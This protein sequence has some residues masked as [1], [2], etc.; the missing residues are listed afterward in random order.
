VVERVGRSGQTTLLNT[1]TSGAIEI[2]FAEIDDPEL[3][4]AR[5]PWAPYWL[6]LP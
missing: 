2:N 5:G 4:P 3:I 1:A 6:K